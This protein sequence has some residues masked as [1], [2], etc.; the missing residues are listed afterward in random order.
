MKIYRNK[1]SAKYFIYI[2]NTGNEEALLVTPEGK[3]KSLKIRLFD[4][5][6]EGDGDYLLSQNLITE[7]QKK[8]YQQCMK[9]RLED[10]VEWYHRLPSYEKKG[11]LESIKEEFGEGWE[12]LKWFK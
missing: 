8:R 7:E 4:G 3:I 2:E 10:L 5:P 6:E 1:S 9:D 11:F 12:K